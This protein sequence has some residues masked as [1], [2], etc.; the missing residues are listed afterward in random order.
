MFDTNLLNYQLFA[1]RTINNYNLRPKQWFPSAFRAAEDERGSIDREIEQLSHL[2][3][4]AKAN[5][6]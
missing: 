2:Y 4:E 1:T 6:L 5:T 3:G